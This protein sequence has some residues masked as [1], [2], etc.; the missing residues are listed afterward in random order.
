[1]FPARSH[2]HRGDH[3][4]RTPRAVYS[5]FRTFL[6]A[7]RRVLVHPLGQ[8]KQYSGQDAGIALA[9]TS[10][11][12]AQVGHS[13]FP[14][15]S[16]RASSR[17]NR[18][19]GRNPGTSSLFTKPIDVI[20]IRVFCFSSGIALPVWSRSFDV[21]A[22]LLNVWV[23]GGSNAQSVRQFHDVEQTERF[24]LRAPLLPRSSCVGQPVRQ[25]LLR[26]SALQPKLA[27]TS[28]NPIT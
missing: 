16:V 9:L 1:M 6:A 23:R 7:C 2:S 4:K 15:G 11:Q 14:S 5:H 18:V 27:Y 19:A 21:T 24:V 8:I 20:C 17:R 12:Q 28:A 3:D 13:W 25:L 22:R 10:E 26:Q